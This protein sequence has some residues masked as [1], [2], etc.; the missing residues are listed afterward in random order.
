MVISGGT[1]EICFSRPWQS[2]LTLLKPKV[3]PF[4]GKNLGDSAQRFP[5]ICHK[6]L[7]I[8]NVRKTGGV[9]K[10]IMPDSCWKEQEIQRLGGAS[11]IEKAFA[12]AACLA[13]QV[14]IDGLLF[15][16]QI[17]LDGGASVPWHLHYQLQTLEEN[18]NRVNLERFLGELR[19]SELVIRQGDGW[20]AVLGG[21]YA[22]QCF[23]VS[24]TQ[25]KISSTGVI[26]TLSAFV[27]DVVDLYNRKF[28]S[29]QS[30]PPSFSIAFVI[31]SDGSI[32]Y[33]ANKP[34]LYHQWGARDWMGDYGLRVKLPWPHEATY[35][36]LVS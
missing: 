31:D 12:V 18:G 4:D 1:T 22:G 20:K 7:A 14:N 36:H 28:V 6:W 24:D 5:H 19:K 2:K 26:Q 21:K 9:N 10:L 13:P 16:V 11:E 3:C 35:R 23:F 25:P 29:T 15:L 27:S 30:L 34:V 32:R 8:D 33:G 17:G